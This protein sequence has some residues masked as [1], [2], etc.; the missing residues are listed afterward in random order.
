MILQKIE[1]KNTD[2]LLGALKNEIQFLQKKN[3]VM[4]F[5][6]ICPF[7]VAKSNKFEIFT[8]LC[9]QKFNFDFLKTL[10]IFFGEKLVKML[11]FWTF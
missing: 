10:S 9:V 2:R 8:L 5:M 4:F 6:S 3:T 11:W 7:T 1:R